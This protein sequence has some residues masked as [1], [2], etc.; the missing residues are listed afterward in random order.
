MKNLVFLSMALVAT[1]VPAQLIFIGPTSFNQPPT[2][3]GGG[4]TLFIDP[5]MNFVDL[6]SGDFSGFRLTD[7]RINYSI[8]PGDLGRTL[9][10]TWSASRPF[11]IIPKPFAPWYNQ[12]A[13]DGSV[14]F[15]EANP[16]NVALDS[17]TLRTFTPNTDFDLGVSAVG[18]SISDTVFSASHVGGPW[19]Q[20]FGESLW[21]TFDLRFH[22]SLTAVVGDSFTLVLPGS[23][24]SYGGSTII[25][26]EPTSTM[27]LGVV[28]L[29]VATSCRLRGRCRALN[30]GA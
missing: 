9:D 5:T 14:S 18:P 10:L 21:Q 19:V 27:L 4:G 3:A 24:G 20:N 6:P 16:G 26:P 8:G 7:V 23:A 2:V 29:A 13:I 30:C 12:S 15:S 17:I 22:V 28:G 1:S 11:T 25:V